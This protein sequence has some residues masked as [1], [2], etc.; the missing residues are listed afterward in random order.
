MKYIPSI[1]LL[2]LGFIGVFIQNYNFIVITTALYLFF[3]ILERL[4]KKIILLESVAFLYTLTCLLIPVFGYKY[5]TYTNILARIWVKYMPVSS[6][7][8]FEFAVPAICLF[9]S[10]LLLPISSSLGGIDEGL[11]TLRQ[12]HKIKEII[13]GKERYG[14][15]IV[16]YGILFYFVS[17][18]LPSTLQFF[19]L[20][21]FFSSFAGIL[22]VYFSPAFRS[23]TLISIFF[24]FFILNTT[25]NSGMFTIIIYMGLTLLSFFL[26]GRKISIWKKFIFFLIAVVLF[27]GI[28]KT[29]VAYRNYIWNKGYEGN[30]FMLFANLFVESFTEGGKI[31]EPDTYF[32]LYVRANQGFNIALVMRRIPTYK[33]HDR[34]EYLFKTIASSVVPR[35]LWPDKPEAGGKIN[36]EYYTGSIILGYSTNVGPLGEAYGSFGV[37]GGVIFMAALGFFIRWFYLTIFKISKKYPLLICWLPV[38]FFQTVYSGETDTL[39][40]MN[41][42]I[43]TSLFI[44]LLYKSFPTIFPKN[45]HESSATL[46]KEE[47]SIL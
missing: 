10:V 20:L 1:I 26:L 9:S 47:L 6:D 32:P 7:R 43:K 16:L 8:Y 45:R 36:M 46:P 42:L 27:S 17:D 31:A 19:A 34:G 44:W 35:F 5:F 23:K 4:G 24:V 30:K 28:Q 15:F 14:A 38:L 22:Y 18:Y 13:K 25:L 39:Q 29:K 41:S 11:F 33:E 37:Y 3:L 21:L 2:F 40:I 12:V